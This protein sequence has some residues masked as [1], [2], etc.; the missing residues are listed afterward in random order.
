MEILNRKLGE[1]GGLCVCYSG[2]ADSAFLALAAR[3]ALG[4]RAAAVLI[5]GA[6]LRRRDFDGALRTAELIGIAPYIIEFDPFSVPEFRSNDKLRCYHCKKAM[7]TRA[8]AFAE[9]LGIRHVA[10]GRNADDSRAHRPGARAAAELGV[11]SPLAE[12]G[13]TK[14]EI[15]EYSRALGLDTWDKPSNSCLATRFPYDTVLTREDF[16]KAEAAENAL[17]GLGV[18]G[19]RVRVHGGIARVE[20][21]PVDFEAVIHSDLARELKNLG[22]R[23]VTLDLEGFRSGSMD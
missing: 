22:F 23:Y 3:R 5:N 9:T 21:P 12:A 10:D 15:R 7:L 17:A 19:G 4:G 11:V 2:G 1:Y 8:Q 20:V 16:E 13:M 6:M 18:A 14:A